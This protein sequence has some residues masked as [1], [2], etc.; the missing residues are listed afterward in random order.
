METNIICNKDGGANQQEQH[1]YREEAVQHSARAQAVQR[2]RKYAQA[3]K[4]KDVVKNG[5]MLLAK[6]PRS[7]LR[8]TYIHVSVSTGL[9]A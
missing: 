9:L 3:N 2:A 5:K 4:T 1:D 6:S 8:Y 7:C